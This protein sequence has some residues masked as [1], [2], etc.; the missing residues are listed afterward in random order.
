MFEG[1]INGNGHTI[2]NLQKP[3]FDEIERATIKNLVIE[4]AYITSKVGSWQ[5]GFIANEIYSKTV[6]SNVHIKNSTISTY[7]QFYTFGPIA[8]RLSGS[9]VEKCSVTNLS[10]VAQRGAGSRR[11]GG[12]VGEIGYG[13]TIED[14]Y[15]TGEIQGS[16]EVGG[17]VGGVQDSM[18]QQNT[19]KHCIAKVN[20][21]GTSGPGNVGGI[22]GN[23]NGAGRI[24]LVQNIS[25]AQGSKSY[26]THGSAI[27]I[28]RAHV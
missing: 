25:L 21:N 3:I 20:I 26:K 2:Y 8:G 24:K 4:N 5:K 7:S 9:R 19:I 17:I 18:Y 27:K 23:A 6:V 15:V 22:A 12:I 28:G 14:C 16:W 10:I 13:S 1:T 11:V